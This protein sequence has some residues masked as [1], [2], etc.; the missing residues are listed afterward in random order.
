[1]RIALGLV[2]L[3]AFAEPEVELKMVV[4]QEQAAFDMSCLQAVQF[5]IDGAT[6]PDDTTD[7]HR[8]CVNVDSPATL[9]DLPNVVR[10]KFG[11]EMPS[12]GLGGIELYGNNARCDANGDVNTTDLLFTGAGE[13]TGE[14]TLPVTVSAT[15]SCTANPSVQVKLVDMF[16]L[17]AT[18]DCAQAAL[19][20]DNGM[21]GAGAGTYSK[22]QRAAGVEFVGDRSGG[23]QAGGV[24]T[25][26]ALDQVGPDA[27][28]A[29]D[30]GNTVN[31]GS[32]S[33]ALS[34][35]AVCATGAQHEIPVVDVNTTMASV[36]GDLVTEYGG[37]VV[38]AVFSASK[39]PVAG[40]TVALDRPELGEV[41]YV[42]P[43]GDLSAGGRFVETA[44]GMTGPSGMFVVYTGD[45][46]TLT[47]SAGGKTQ[48]VT[49]ADEI[50]VDLPS[51][52]A[53]ALIVMP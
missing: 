4:P 36:D 37:V 52:P 44:D 22:N 24:V 49:V 51:G 46:V 35:P 13:Y 48:S 31:L 41:H 14:L 45:M 33:C 3:A 2:V 32:V 20:D 29:F 12:S 10:G 18:G 53:A 1:M 8:S 25:M 28:L 21:T 23:G 43:Q 19:P 38:G 50:G 26:D 16:K 6:Y 42:E 17:I 11:G 40:A 9:A 27:C 39:Q 7:S 30:A 34:T 15:V 47:V 5:Y